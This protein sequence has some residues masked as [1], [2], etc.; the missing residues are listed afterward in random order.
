[1]QTSC[2][3][4]VPFYDYQGEREALR[5]H[6]ESLGPQGIQDY[7]QKKNVVSIDGLPTN[8]FAGSAK[9]TTD[10]RR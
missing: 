9:S 10:K 1:M 2:G 5:K 8:L 6:A 7:W 3:F 4:A